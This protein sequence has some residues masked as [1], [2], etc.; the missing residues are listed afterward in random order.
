MRDQLETG[1]QVVDRFME[2]RCLMICGGDAKSSQSMSALQRR[3]VSE[4][5]SKFGNAELSRMHHIGFLDFSKLGRLSM[6]DINQAVSWAK[7]I[8]QMNEE[9]SSLLK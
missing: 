9:Y 5:C 8:L 2:K 4:A 6:V 7:R 1:F 3:V